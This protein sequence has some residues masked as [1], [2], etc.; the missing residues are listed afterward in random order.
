MKKHTPFRPTVLAATI[1]TVCS[2]VSANV[3]AQE[4]DTAA[5][6]SEYEVIEVSGIRRSLVQAMDIK[7]SSDGVVDAISAEDIGKFPDTNLA[8]SL[9]RITGVSIDR[10]NNEGS[11]VTVRGWGPQFNLITLNGRQM[12]AANLTAT[13]I[14]TDRSFD[15][16]NLASE[17][18]TG[19]EVY[20][21]GRADI[22]TGGIGATINISTHKP[23]S[24]PGTRA[25]VAVKAINDDTRVG[26]SVTPEI[27]GLFSKTFADD[28]IGVSVVA[29]RS[30]RDN[31]AASGQVTSGWNTS[32]VTGQV[33][34]NAGDP[35]L[36]VGSGTAILAAPQNFMYVFEDLSRTRTN[37]Q[38]TL[39]YAPSDKVKATLD[40]TYSEFE[41][42]VNRQELSAWFGGGN[43]AGTTFTDIDAAGVVSPLVLNNTD[44]CDYGYGVGS[45]GTT[46]ENKSFGFNVEWQATDNLKVV[47]DA[48][49][50]EAEAQ[51]K[52]HRGSNNI[53]T[54]GTF[55]RVSTMVDFTRDIPVMIGNMNENLDP[56][57]IIASGNSFRNGYM[58]TDIDQFQINGTYTFD[59]GIVSSID[60]GASRLTMENRTAF[61]LNQGGDWGGL[62]Y[63]GH[64]TGGDWNAP[65]GDGDGNFSDAA[66]T[67]ADLN[68]I[69]G[70][71]NIGIN[72]QMVWVDFNQFT[73]DIAALYSNYPTLPGNVFANCP[74]GTLCVNPE[75]SNDLRL[76]EEQTAFYLQANLVFDIGEMPARMKVGVR[77]E[78]TD[79]TSNSLIPNYVDQEWRTPNELI[80]VQDGG[81]FASGE[82]DYSSFLPNVDFQVD[83]TDDIVARASYSHTLARPEY[84]DL[85]AG[86]VPGSSQ[87]RTFDASVASAGDPSLDPFESKNIDLSL[88]FYYAEGSYASIGY[89]TKDVEN[90]IGTSVEQRVIYPDLVNPATGERLAEAQATVVN[91]GNAAQEIRDYYVAQGWVTANGQLVGDT[92][93]YDPLVHTVTVPVN[94]EDATIDGF[95]FAVQHIFGES[96]FGFNANYTIVD[97]DVG[98]DNSTIGEDQVALMG[99]SDSANLVAFYDKDGLQIRLAYNWRDV[100]LSGTVGGN[101]QQEP[102]YTEAY[103]QLD[104]SINYE[105]T[106]NLIVSLEGIN[107]T[108]EDRRVHARGNSMVIFAGEQSARYAL[109]V[110]YNF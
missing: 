70:P 83:L 74:T 12:P 5:Q 82:G 13:A 67:I 92:S 110:R 96:G 87:A 1:A 36:N 79:V 16:A 57:A 48:H 59:D 71:D 14:N 66:F 85:Q 102:A 51:P 78:S 104:I 18:V 39:Q 109:G 19:V 100:F 32:Q 81:V 4:A 46:N 80:L 45:W 41:Q 105:V 73:S 108:E 63:T 15:F 35:L 93:S 28:T 20:K 53:V 49:S 95:E 76:E 21:T 77:H 64:T 91:D 47:F 99:L 7:R 38:V 23:L 60:F 90:F 2:G 27:S 44:C 61:S 6:D 24:N 9:Q 25:T 54:A 68:D 10:Q 84:D 56:S 3:I 11:R 29:S 31:F 17:S 30:E 86:A 107:I 33:L 34:D 55:R 97:G 89:Y 58:K 98:Y 101:G 103:S 40:Y 65:A 42:D 88:E 72:G 50:S 69:P 106:E 22:T 37:A 26:D 62:G 75:Y 94:S 8:E 52:D 43:Y